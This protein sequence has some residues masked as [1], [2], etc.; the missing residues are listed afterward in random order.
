MPGENEQIQKIFDVL[1]RC[2]PDFNTTNGF[3]NMTHSKFEQISCQ[4]K[5]DG[6]GEAQKQPQNKEEPRNL[7]TAVHTN[8]SH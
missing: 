1:L 6:I 8:T 4:M 3:A 5:I 7:G 2:S